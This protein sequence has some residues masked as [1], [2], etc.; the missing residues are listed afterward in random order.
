MVWLF[1]S[2]PTGEGNAEELLQDWRLPKALLPIA[3][4]VQPRDIAVFHGV[5][6]PDKLSRIERWML[7]NVK[8]PSGDFRDWDSI[9]AWAKGVANAVKEGA[10]RGKNEEDVG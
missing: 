8:A 9:T 3:E 4:Q 2:G 5:V 10:I 6:D 1:S 7:K